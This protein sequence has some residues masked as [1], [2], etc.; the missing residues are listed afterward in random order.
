[1]ALGLTLL[2]VLASYRITRLVAQDTILKAPR[3]RILNDG[4]T[5]AGNLVTCPFC[6]GFWIALAVAGATYLFEPYPLPAL[7][8]VAVAGGSSLIFDLRG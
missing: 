5:W 7:T 3:E 6:I 8:A 4:P 2:M 1:M